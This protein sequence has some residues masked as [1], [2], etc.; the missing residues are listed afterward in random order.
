MV[1]TIR[2]CDI[3]M[4]RR[5]FCIMFALAC[6]LL[7]VPTFGQDT[8][9]VTVSTDKQ[10]YDLG[11]AVLIT[12][13][14]R[15]FGAPVANAVVYFEL[16]DPQNQVRAKGFEGVTDSSGKLSWQIMIGNDFR[17]GSYVVYVSV[18]AGGQSATAQTAF[19]TIPEFSSILVLV[20]AVAM[21]VGMLD[22]YRAKERACSAP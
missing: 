19:Q 16:R 21:T 20:V 13:R 6:M 9:S 11:Q 8:L 7:A 14:V 15:Q 5:R 4:S 18:N 12:V 1:R 10:D 2:V 22:V 17:L 3:G